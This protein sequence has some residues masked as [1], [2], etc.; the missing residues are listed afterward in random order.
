MVKTEPAT[1]LICDAGPLIHL[2]ELGI[3]SLL[4]DFHPILIPPAVWGEVETHRPSAISQSEISL[5]RSPPPADFK[6]PFLPLV[7]AFSLDAG[8]KEAILLM[9][10]HSNALLITDDAAARL[11]AEQ[12]GFR[13]HGTIGI[14][15]RAI[16]RK[17]RSREE[18]ISLIERIPTHSSLHIR[19][20]LLKEIL[21]QIRK[22]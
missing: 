4:S 6:V 3:L 22:K 12:L 5:V 16:R 14:I 15:I 13:V 19:P 10:L 8:E 9:H 7:Q 1:T 20:S 17:Q 2:D 11:V 18:V 21:V